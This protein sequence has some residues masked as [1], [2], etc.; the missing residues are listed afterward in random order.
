LCPARRPALSDAPP[1]RRGSKPVFWRPASYRKTGSSSR[2][3]DTHP[4]PPTPHPPTLPQATSTAPR[5]LTFGASGVRPGGGHAPRSRRQRTLGPGRS[6]A[7]FFFRVN[8]SPRGLPVRGAA[9]LQRLV[10]L[11]DRGHSTGATPLLA[12]VGGSYWYHSGLWTDPVWDPLR[13]SRSTGENRS[14]RASRSALRALSSPWHLGGQVS[15]VWHWTPCT[16]PGT[17]RC[18]AVR[19]VITGILHTAVWRQRPGGRHVRAARARRPCP[20][21]APPMTQGAHGSRRAAGGA[22]C[23]GGEVL[24]AAASAA[25][26][27]QSRSAAP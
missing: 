17:L 1:T 12:L 16:L 9:R 7:R 19:P 5:G 21:G 4:T 10:S 18:W 11:V 22:E 24:V 23:R 13:C 14:Q 6:G 20:F 3:H 26:P 2:R 25:A 15:P 8:T 27:Y